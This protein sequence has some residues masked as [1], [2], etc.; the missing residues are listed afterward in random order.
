M[1]KPEQMSKVLVFGSKKDLKN[2][3]DTLHRMKVYHIVEYDPTKQNS[4]G[5]SDSHNN[6]HK[7]SKKDTKN[8]EINGNGRKLD[9]GTP[10]ELN[11]QISVSAI[12]S[13]SL[14]SLW[15]LAKKNQDNQNGKKEK[16]ENLSLNE[17]FTRVDS[18]HS[19][20]LILTEKLKHEKESLEQ[21]E[22]SCNLNTV[23][24]SLNLPYEYIDGMKSVVCIIGSI[25]EENIHPLKISLN[26]AKI[27]HEISVSEED[28]TTYIA[29]AVERKKKEDALKVMQQYQFNQIDFSGFKGQERD[30]EKEEDK[31]DSG[32]TH[33]ESQIESF[34]EK[35]TS[36]IIFATKTLSIE[37]EKSEAP[38]KFAS[39]RN[40]FFVTGFVPKKDKEDLI[41]ELE[42]V[43]DE[44]IYIEEHEIGK[45]DTVPIKFDN[46]KSVGNFEFILNLYSLPK[47]SELDPT[48]IAFLTFPILFGFMLGDIGYGLVTLILFIILKKF[49]PSTKKL[50]NIFIF[51]SVWT[52]V[53]GFVF[54]E[55]FGAEELMGHELPHLIH[56]LTHI[57]EL[58]VIAIVIG[59]VHLN[60][61][62]F[63]G[64]YNEW[65][66]HGFWQAFL[67]KMSWVFLEISIA[68]IAAALYFKSFS[69]WIGGALAFVSA[70]MIYKG[71][72]LKG[73]IELPGLFSNILSYS[74]LMAIG[75]ASAG[76]AI[77][78]NE[79][80]FEMFHGGIG[81]IIGAVF[82]LLFGHIINMAL[83]LIGP[84]LHSLRLHYVEFFTKFYHGGGQP[85]KP[86]GEEKE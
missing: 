76:L 73:L 36:F 62:Y 6:R 12:K 3:I 53:F 24:D 32:I 70:F 7:E 43:T 25:K 48:A 40:L 16:F 85:F 79:F 38:L 22:H 52:I 59:V 84:F 23:L 67:E 1:L 54:G 28:N 39:S 14:Y 44:R 77:V 47:Y 4:N 30:F 57:N 72:G 49:I 82:I 13:K 34:K 74:R 9:I 31:A 21:L 26:K 58:M 10:L 46:P 64:F 11:E 2:V 5:N 80:A 51:S 33:V 66:N 63:I 81:S 55:F 86:F 56:R 78:V 65:K 50:A 68:L 83:G 15:D 19:E 45:H 60:M 41:D 8:T 37:S 61:G 75:L 18:I 69:P 27:S 20:Y 17:I 29:L 35:N 42:H 71:E